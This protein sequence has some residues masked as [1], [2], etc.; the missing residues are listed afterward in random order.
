MQIDELL[1]A[2]AEL[3]EQDL[4]E[5]DAAVTRAEL[6]LTRLRTLRALA[7]GKR[8]PP[9]KS[10]NAETNS[11][12]HK[13]DG[14]R[15]ER[16]TAAEMLALRLDIA[17]HIAARGPLSNTAIGK[18]VGE[19]SGAVTRIMSSPWFERE[20]DGYHLTHEGR[21]ALRGELVATGCT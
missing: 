17:R 19:P 13:D 4:G 20:T 9:A 8:L 7:G 3:G 5:I 6:H 1:D 16:R 10:A 21:L 14:E 2:L 11:N 12:G 18:L 15:R